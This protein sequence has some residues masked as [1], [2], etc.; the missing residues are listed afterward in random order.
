MVSR[1]DGD[2]V[3]ATGSARNTAALRLH[4][5]CWS[6]VAYGPATTSAILKDVNSNKFVLCSSQL[7]D[8]KMP[9]ILAGPATIASALA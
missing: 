1:G 4:F 9:A 3:R 7:H 5:P 2:Y 8:K 6:P